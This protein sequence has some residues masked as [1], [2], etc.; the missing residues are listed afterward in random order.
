MGEVYRL[1]HN[2]NQVLNI[3]EVLASFLVVFIHFPFPGRLGNIVLAIARISVPLFFCISGF[4]FN[5]GD[6]NAELKSVPKKILHLIKLILF[7][8][9]VYFLFYLVLQIR[10]VGISVQ[11]IKNVIEGEI[12]G[13]YLPDLLNRLVV[14]APPFNGICWFIGSLIVVYLF[15][16]VTTK[17]GCNRVCFVVSVILLCV[18]IILRRVLFYLLGEVAF[19]YE[20]LLPFLPLPFFFIGYHLKR[21]VKVLCDIS[22]TKYLV[23]CGGCVTLVG[24]EHFWGNH[25]L[26]MFVPPLVVL[27]MGWCVKH[28]K[29]EVKSFVGKLLSYLGEYSSTWIYIFHMIIGHCVNTLILAMIPRALD[30]TLYG[31]LFPIIVCIASACFAGVFGYVKNWTVKKLSVTNK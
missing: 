14:F 31:Y 5:K 21:N 11:A 29:Y 2:R 27:L 24:I 16:W 9:V 28:S 15:A 18:G 10:S 4:F 25:T 12:V 22:D 26:P 30:N 1:R 7:S 23:L 19:P 3:V 20:R 6:S 17:F 8:E 13:Y